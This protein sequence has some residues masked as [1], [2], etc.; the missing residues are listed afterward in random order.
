MRFLEALRA[1]RVPAGP[2]AGIGIAGGAPGLNAV[3]EAGLPGGFDLV[4]MANLDP[5]AAERIAQLLRE[6]LAVKE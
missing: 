5:P 2:P 6:W 3:V 4:A 1:G